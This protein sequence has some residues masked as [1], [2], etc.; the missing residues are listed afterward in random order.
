MDENGWLK[1]TILEIKADIKDLASRFTDFMQDR[2]RTC[3]TAAELE[4]EEE[5][6]AREEESRARQRATK[7]AIIA[8]VVAVA[9]GIPAWIGALK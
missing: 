7:W 1:E 9:V 2:R 6:K 4:K 8:V 5:R 3:P